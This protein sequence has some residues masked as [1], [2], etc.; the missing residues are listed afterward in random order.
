MALHQKSLEGK[1]FPEDVV[2]SP[3]TSSVLFPLSW[4]CNSSSEPCVVFNKR[5]VRVRQPGDLCFP[6]GRV[7]PHLDSFLSKV[8]KSP[9]SPLARW[10]FWPQWRDH[11]REQADR[12]SLLFATSLRE[13]MEEMRLNP[14]GVT[15][16]GPM[17]PEDLRM[18]RRIL[19]PMVAWI[20]RQRHFLPNW[21][22]EKIVYVP[23]RK[24]LDPEA[25][26][27]YRLRFNLDKGKE[28]EGCERDFPCFRHENEKEKEVLWG[29]TFRIVVSF[30]ETVFEFAVPPL[31]SLPV[32]THTLDQR[33]VTG[34]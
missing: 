2:L 14:F 30:L 27:C 29:A 32:I 16:L 23:L 28:S 34:S 1:G 19:Y 31:D 33:Y 8:L 18:F 5:S 4:H 21:E 10:R 24:L 17:P 6:G 12:L 3:A 25:Y 11:Q 15:F 7:A 9:F 22:V 26:A 13:S 20:H